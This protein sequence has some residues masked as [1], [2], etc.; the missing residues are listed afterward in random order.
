MIGVDDDHGTVYVVAIDGLGTRP[1]DELPAQV[2]TAAS[3]AINRTTDAAR[4]LA[5]RTIR[6]QVNF[7]ASYLN[8]SDQRLFVADRATAQKL[9]AKISARTRPTMLARF[10]SSSTPNK[11]GV[12]VEVAPGFAKFMRRAFLIRLPAGRG[13]DVDTKSNLGLAIRL[14]PGEVIHNKHVMA[15]LKGNLYLL[16]GPSVSQVFQSVR[17]DISPEV[18]DR[19][20]TEFARLMQ[21]GDTLQ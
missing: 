3:R 2:L 7:P 12:T 16:Y 4:T 8:P 14:K 1:L 17:D 20:A 11:Q 21:L 19:L 18:S 6:Q 5:A 15:R 9:Q 13:G 10:A